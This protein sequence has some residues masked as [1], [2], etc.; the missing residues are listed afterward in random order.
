VAVVAVATAILGR[1]HAVHADDH[2]GPR[3]PVRLELAACLAEAH[4]AI[5]RAV[6]V[7]VGESPE[8]DDASAIAVAVECAAGGLDAGVVIE[9]RP[10][11]NPRRYRYA[12]DWRA[13]PADARPRLIGLAVAEAVDA[14]R[15]ELTAVPEPAIVVGPGPGRST[16][17]TGGAYP[18]SDWRIAITGV[19]RVFS[20]Q[21][22]V[23]LLG[24]GLIA[25]RRLPR[26]L[27]VSADLLAETT[28]VLTASGAVA[29]LSVSSA[30]RIAVRVGHR[31]H[32]EL[33][34][35]ARVGIV[36]MRGDALPGSQFAGTSQLRPWFGPAA[37]LAVDIDVTPRLS[38]R[39]SAELGIVGAGATA[40]D[41]GAAV[42]ALGGVWTA[43]GVAATLEL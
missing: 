39:A 7:E 34:A 33:G 25:A 27:V 10:P 11:G 32:G 8:A 43:L 28:T 15:I 5:E 41:F 2:A 35:G 37:D 42:A 14:S 29:V 4:D 23:D 6:Q 12:L 40:R 17:A 18:A 9:V 13:Q 21:A 3:P 24:V 22:G 38:L 30:P 20:A 26:H 19:R 36:R 31:V 1:S 16:D